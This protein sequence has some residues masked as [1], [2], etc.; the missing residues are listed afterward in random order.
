MSAIPDILPFLHCPKLNLKFLSPTYCQKRKA[1]KVITTKA[2]V[3][4][5][6][7]NILVCHECK[8]PITILK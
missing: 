7:P 1:M 5:T 3:V 6:D 2:G 4:M 8:E